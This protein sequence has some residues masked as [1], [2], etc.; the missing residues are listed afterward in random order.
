M[1]TAIFDVDG[2]IVHG[3]CAK[4][5]AKYLYKKKIFS[6]S[7]VIKFNFYLLYYLLLIRLNKLDKVRASKKWVK[8]ISNRLL[9]DNAVRLG[10]EC[11]NKKIK[12]K[13]IKGVLD[14]LKKHAKKGDRII[15]LSNSPNFL[16]KPLADYL[17]VKELYGTD[18]ICENNKFK[19]IKLPLCFGKG[20]TEIVNKLKIDLKD[21]YAYSD[22]IHDLPLLELVKYPHVVNPNRRFKKEALKRDW[23]VY[24]FKC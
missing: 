20:K 24:H 21:S 19:A 13:L 12:P 7:F 18:F 1:S 6:L 2:T 10:E 11:F 5:Y 23:P 17:N 4:I 15:L 22:S 16:L 9:V 3:I 8:E 14:I